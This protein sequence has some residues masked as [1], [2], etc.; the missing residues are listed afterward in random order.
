MRFRIFLILLGAVAVVAT[1]TFPLWQ[2]L[3]TATGV[4]EDRLPGLAPELQT[5]FQILPADQQAAYLSI[6]DADMQM[7]INLIRAAL[8]PDQAVSEADQ[9]M[10]ELMAP[11]A[12]ASGGFRQIN[13][14]QGGEGT[15]TIYETADNRKVL[16][17]EN[18]RVTNGPELHVVLSANPAPATLEE[19]QLNDLD[20]ELGLL[21]GNLGSQNYEIPAETDLSLYNSVVIICRRYGMVFSTAPI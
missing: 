19:V 12:V 6:V 3:F 21:K 8:S 20:L 17:F 11:V 16:R 14:I 7:G 10:P 13:V 18:F 5:A 9:A 1:F 4:A 2:P 15:A